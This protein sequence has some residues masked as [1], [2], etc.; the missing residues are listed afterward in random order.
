MELAAREDGFAA[1]KRQTSYWADLASHDTAAK[2]VRLFGLGA[3]AV[4]RRAEVE[5]PWVNSLWR[6]RGVV[7]G[8]QFWILGLSLLAGAA[9]LGLPGL[10]VLAGD[11]GFGDLAMVTSAAFAVFRM[12]NMGHEQFDIE[13]GI[14]SIRAYDRLGPEGRAGDAAVA[15]PGA[16][17]A[18]VMP[19]RTAPRRSGPPA[20]AFEGVGYR[21]AS[22]ETPPLDGLDLVLEPGRVTAIVGDNGA[23]KTTMMKLLGGLYAPTAGRVRA[24]GADLAELDAS[25][26]RARLAVLFQDFIRYPLSVAENIGLG[27]GETIVDKSDLRAAVA[28]AGA[29]GLVAALPEGFATPLSRTRSGGM[30]LSGG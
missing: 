1:K 26:W 29:A 9:A 6:S 16:K 11:L 3:W 30:D 15:V 28:S 4:R 21:Y 12:A 25:A 19:T 13:R 2:E 10:A 27:A 18:A 7:Y 20:I 17:A 8:R 22:A 5:D 14:K 23:G 24:D